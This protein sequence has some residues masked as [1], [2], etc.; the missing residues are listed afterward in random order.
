MDKVNVSCWLQTLFV[1][2]ERLLS[3]N[4]GHITSLICL[5]GTGTTE[6]LYY[7]QCGVFARGGCPLLMKNGKWSILGRQGSTSRGEGATGGGRGEGGREYKD[8]AGLRRG[9]P[10]D[11]SLSS[12]REE[13]QRC[14]VIFIS[15]GGQEEVW[16]I[17]EG[18]DARMEGIKG[19]G[20]SK[21][22]CL[23]S[24]R[25]SSRPLICAAHCLPVVINTRRDTDSEPR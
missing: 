15:K 24:S 22:V 6:P 23:N 11:R 21:P 16:S 7:T 14:E 18:K 4:I 17:E 9:P 3:N 10:V 25:Q 13:R 20:M 1:R 2:P 8:M 19:D 5:K 12:E